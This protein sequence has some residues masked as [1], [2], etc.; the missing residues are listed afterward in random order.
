MQ[1]VIARR[2]LVNFRVRPEVLAALLPGPFRPKLVGGFGLVGICLIR[3]EQVRPY[4][5]PAF[6]GLSS[7]NAAHRF[8]VEWTRQGR[9][10]QG[11]FIPRRDTDA[12]L[13]RLAGGRVFPG[14]NQAADFTVEDD[15]DRV[16]LKVR[17]HDGP[18]TLNVT[19][20]SAATLPSSSVFGSLEE[21]SEFFQGG[22]VGWSVANRPD[23]C[24]GLELVCER[25]GAQPFAVESVA[26]SY[27]DDPVR[28]P[29]GSVEFDSALVMRGIQHHWRALGHFKLES[30]GP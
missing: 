24:D 5:L 8:A 19:G 10:C 9:S 22:T 21:A 30:E 23:C 3:L 12:W 17:S 15:G 11:V 27:F 13:N 4:G 18:M 1:G 2:L 28:F 14:Y 29:A 7:E 26:A 6:V 20:R 25:W 16:A